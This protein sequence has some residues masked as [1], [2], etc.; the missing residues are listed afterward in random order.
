VTNILGT[1]Y[2][3]VLTIGERNGELHATLV[4]ETD[5]EI[6]LRSI[7]FEDRILRYVY[8][9]PPSQLSW[10][11]DS[12]EEIETWLKVHDDSLTGAL[13]GGIDSEIDFS[14]TGRRAAGPIRSQK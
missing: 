2:N 11:K 13:S 12:T 9:R 3:A 7:T 8:A 5:G 10:Q 4:D 6:D 1:E 14:V